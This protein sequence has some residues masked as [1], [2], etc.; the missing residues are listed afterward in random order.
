[1]E[2]TV[3]I[4]CVECDVVSMIIV[5]ENYDVDYCPSCGILVEVDEDDIIRDVDWDEFE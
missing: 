5:E 1:M 3:R 4:G 2:K